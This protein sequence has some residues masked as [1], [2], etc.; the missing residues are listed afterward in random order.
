MEDVVWVFTSSIPAWPDTYQHKQT[1]MIIVVRS[2][3][4]DYL[5][6]NHMTFILQFVKSRLTRRCSFDSYHLIGS[7]PAPIILPDNQILASSVNT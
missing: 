4:S 3:L 6:T 1:A 5:I 2:P 7:F